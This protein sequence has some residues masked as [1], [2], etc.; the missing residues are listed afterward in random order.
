MAVVEVDTER[1]DEVRQ[2]V[3]IGLSRYNDRFL[4]RERDRFP[5]ALSVRDDAGAVVGGLIGELRL[6][7]L[8][9][10][11][12]W[13]DESQR[14]TGTGRRLIELA[15]TEAR[16]FGADHIHLWTWDFQAPEFYRAM[17]FSEFGRMDNHPAGVTTFMFVKA[18]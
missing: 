9:V 8:Y 11:L 18:I 17:G 15:E 1:F 4:P 14:G 12:L 2:A 3:S 13:I 10:D 6:N 5:F 7:W 16:K